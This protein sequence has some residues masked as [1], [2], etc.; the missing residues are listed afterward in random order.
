VQEDLAERL[1]DHFGASR[2]DLIT[3]LARPAPTRSQEFPL[4]DEHENTTRSRSLLF[5]ALALLAASACGPNVPVWMPEN[6]YI[7]LNV[8]LTGAR[9]GSLSTRTTHPQFIADLT[10]VLGAVGLTNE[11]RN[12][13]E[14]MTKGEVLARSVRNDLL[15]RLAPR[16]I[17]CAHPEANRYDADPSRRRFANCGYCYP[18]IVRRAAMH[19]VGWDRGGDYLYDVLRDPRLLERGSGRGEDARA[20]VAMI[21]DRKGLSGSPLA[22]LRSGPLPAGTNLAAVAAMHRRGSDELRDLFSTASGRVKKF[23]E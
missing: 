22:V 10:S 9:V 4:P 12:P 1:A 23:T 13:F 11:I 16:T 3:V 2:V 7:S 17:S 5:I 21:R 20:V 6:A 8:P 19:K 14:N 18:C 15:A